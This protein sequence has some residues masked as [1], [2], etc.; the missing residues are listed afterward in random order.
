VRDRAGDEVVTKPLSFVAT[1][2]A[3]LQTGAKRVFRDVCPQGGILSSRDEEKAITGKT[4]A[5]LLSPVW[6]DGRHERICELEQ[7]Y[8]LSLLEDRGSLR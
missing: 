1:A 6:P 2:T 4:K 7:K 3:I 5:L 8:H